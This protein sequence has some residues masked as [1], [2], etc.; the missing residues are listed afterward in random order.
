MATDL[1]PFDQ[2]R[3]AQ[4]FFATRPTAL[5]RFMRTFIPWQFWRFV[6]INVKM[7]RVIRKS[8]H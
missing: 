1:S 2:G 3:Q 5:T 7:I 8:H 4:A 6:V